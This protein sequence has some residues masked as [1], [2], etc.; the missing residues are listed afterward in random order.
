LDHEP[1]RPAKDN[2]E[3]VLGTKIGEGFPCREN[4]IIDREE[5]HAVGES[6]FI[7]TIVGTPETHLEQEENSSQNLG[8]TKRIRR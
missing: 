7:R 1:V 2:S 3:S 5:K 6:R 4:C 8:T